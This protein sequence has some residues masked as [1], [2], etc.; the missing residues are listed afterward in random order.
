MQSF[1]SSLG[2]HTQ[3]YSLSFYVS[4]GLVHLTIP[5]QGYLLPLISWLI[6]LLMGR[7]S[8]TLCPIV[9]TPS[10]VLLKNTCTRNCMQPFFI[11]PLGYH[12][13]LYSLSFYV[14][15]GLVHLS[16]PCFLHTNTLGGILTHWRLLLTMGDMIN[17]NFFHHFIKTLA[18][19]TQILNHLILQ[20]EYI[21]RE[22]IRHEN[23]ASI[24]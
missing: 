24:Q 18:S 16:I 10:P 2:Q 22:L 15:I 7:L 1:I 5:W 6:S 19:S 11:S 12:T 4:L 8:T 13:Q 14:S 20:C 21:D 23:Q 3:F 9:D 17:T